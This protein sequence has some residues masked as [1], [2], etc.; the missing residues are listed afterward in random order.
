M[1]GKEENIIMGEVIENIQTKG[2]K[3][4]RQ[5]MERIVEVDSVGASIGE[6]VIVTTGGVSRN[7]YNMKD[8]SID[9]AII[10]IIDSLEE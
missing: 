2:F 4:L 9:T 10:E 6:K 5:K 3:L 1:E 7:I 8:K